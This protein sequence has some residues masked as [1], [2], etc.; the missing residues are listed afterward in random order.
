MTASPQF[1]DGIVLARDTFAQLDRRGSKWRTRN[2]PAYIREQL[3]L[4]YYIA[5]QSG[6]RQLYIIRSPND[7][8]PKVHFARWPPPEPE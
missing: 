1:E 3:W 8:N 2:V 7:Q 4:P 6:E 5:E